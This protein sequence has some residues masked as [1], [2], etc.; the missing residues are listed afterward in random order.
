MISVTA[1]THPGNVRTRNED[2]IVLPGLVSVG[3]P[4]MPVTIQYSTVGEPLLF[5]V[6]DGLGGHRGGQE[7]SRLVAQYFLDHA[8]LGIFDALASAN[9]ALYDAM[10]HSPDLL[11]M[12]ATVAGALLNGSAATIFNVGDSRVYQFAEGYLMLLSIDDRVNS[13]S[14]AVMQSLGG[15]DRPTDI[16]PHIT[17]LDLIDQ[18]LL[19]LC[20]DGLSEVVPF[21]FIQSVLSD[22]ESGGA[23]ERLLQAV[24]AAGAPDNVSIL[25]LEYRD[26]G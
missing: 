17:Q 26:D 15:A 22:R 12:G 25:I 9:R 13:S 2:T 23:V 19:L 3:S 8:T 18:Q 10:Q 16:V 21:D 14:Q 24:L 5:A 11:G 4:P 6:V 7:A 1:I 20:S